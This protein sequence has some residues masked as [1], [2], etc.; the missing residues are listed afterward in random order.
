MKNNIIK[1]LLFYSIIVTTFYSYSMEMLLS[2]A[3]TKL[4]KQQIDN[5]AETVL[6]NQLIIPYLLKLQITPDSIVHNVSVCER[7]LLQHSRKQLIFLD[8]DKDA[9]LQLS[10]PT[11]KYVELIKT[12]NKAYTTIVDETIGKIALWF[13]NEMYIYETQTGELIKKFSIPD[14]P[15][16]LAFGKDGA[17]LYTLNSDNLVA[18]WN[19]NTGLLLYEFYTEPGLTICMNIETIETKTYLNFYYYNKE[20]VLLKNQY[21]ISPIIELEYMLHSTL[22]LAQK[23]LL[24]VIQ[25]RILEKNS[26]NPVLLSEKTRK[27]YETLPELIKKHLNNWVIYKY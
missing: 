12:Y 4:T 3:K 23:L 6:D 27:I 10:I 19:V 1:I 26:F 11:S 22:N 24:R 20:A 9:T 5:I 15:L 14:R 17:F 13:S 7:S 21:D 8:E 18:I 25:E 2:G 16:F